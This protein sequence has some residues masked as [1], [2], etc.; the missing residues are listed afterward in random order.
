[1]KMKKFK[2]M[3]Y[4]ILTYWLKEILESLKNIYKKMIKK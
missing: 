2:M 1:M 3:I 4:Q